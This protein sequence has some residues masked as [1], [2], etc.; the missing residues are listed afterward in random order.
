M[1]DGLDVSLADPR[2]TISKATAI[3]LARYY[4]TQNEIYKLF[5]GV[6]FGKSVHICETTAMS[7]ARCGA[8]GEKEIIFTIWHLE[9]PPLRYKMSRA[10]LMQ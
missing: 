8:I 2:A 1:A 10:E 7:L 6:S 9:R 5:Q 3:T 4:F